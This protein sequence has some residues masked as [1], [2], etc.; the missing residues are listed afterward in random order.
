MRVAPDYPVRVVVF[1]HGADACKLVQC[2]SCALA[3][4]AENDMSVRIVDDY[5]DPLPDTVAEALQSLGRVRYGRSRFRR[6]GNLNGRDCI[7]AEAGVFLEEAT[8]ADFREDALVVKLDSDTLLAKRLLFDEAVLDSRTGAVAC[9]VP[10]LAE[11]W[12]PMYCFRANLAPAVASILKGVS[13]E[14]FRGEGGE[15]PHEDAVVGAAVALA[16]AVHAPRY[17]DVRKV[18]PLDEGVSGRT[19]DFVRSRGL[20][21]YVW[22]YLHDKYGVTDETVKSIVD[23]NAVVELGDGFHV[24]N[25]A[26]DLRGQNRL[27]LSFA[28]EVQHRAAYDE[29]EWFHETS[30]TV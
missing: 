5:A 9:S 7:L 27:M 11:W 24:N 30:R 16:C 1:T 22:D 3:V 10:N 14:M 6:G 18:Y 19:G 17:Y 12:G 4:F 21:L 25:D 29:H 28:A 15:L 20:G 8:S 26:M 23:A 13:A 2:V